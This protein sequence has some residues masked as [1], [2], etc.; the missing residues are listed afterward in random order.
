MLNGDCNLTLFKVT[1]DLDQAEGGEG[2][3]TFTPG[4]YIHLSSQ[5]SVYF[6]F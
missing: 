4:I 5:L 1:L 2:G 3:F 6:S